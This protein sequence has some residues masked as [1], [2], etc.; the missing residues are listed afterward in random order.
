M[1]LFDSKARSQ[2]LS[3]AGWDLS[4]L[5]RRLRFSQPPVENLNQRLRISTA[6]WD[7]EKSQPAVEN[8]DRW[9]RFWNLTKNSQPAVENLD[10]RVRISPGGWDLNRWLSSTGG[11]DFKHKSQPEVEARLRFWSRLIELK[12]MQKLSKN[13]INVIWE[14]VS[15]PFFT[16]YPLYNRAFV[17]FFNAIFVCFFPCSKT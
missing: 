8:L 12:I 14:T 4:N 1:K 10:Q 11:W 3:T 9:L 6:G 13:S 2:K 7:L 17:S 5:T 16:L 15:I